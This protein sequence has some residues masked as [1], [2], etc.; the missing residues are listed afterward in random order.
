VKIVGGAEFLVGESVDHP[1]FEA[2][3]PAIIEEWKKTAMVEPLPRGSAKA[4]L[5]TESFI[6]AASFQ[7]AP[8]F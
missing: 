3:N 4:S 2:I 8:R 5:T 7:E 1:R 6:A